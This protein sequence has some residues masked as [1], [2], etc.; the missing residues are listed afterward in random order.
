MR[1][2]TTT[3]AI[4]ALV[5]MGASSASAI[6]I[7]FEGQANGQAI[8]GGEFPGV[9]ISSSDAGVTHS[10]P[11]IFDSNPAGPNAAGG[12]PDLLVNTGNL[13]I[14]QNNA[15]PTQTTPGIFDTPNDEADYGPSN[16]GHLLFSFDPLGVEVQSILLVDL[17]GGA[18]VDI[19]LT[20][21][22]GNT[23][24]YFVPE[25]WTKDIADCGFTCA[26][27]KVF[28]LQTLA[29]QVGEEPSNSTTPAPTVTGAYD[30][31][32]V[33][34]MELRFHG[35]SPSAAVDN[36]SFVPEPSTALLLG[37]GLAAMAGT[38]RRS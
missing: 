5:L 22:L 24:E 26:G 18:E 32:S 10:G 6:T 4:G 20:D 34:S 3:A 21:V 14:L 31:F 12:D 35:T 38:R 15:F 7:D 8:S 33:L 37:L 36:L 25:M 19:I 30:K 9:T 16:E 23:L 28:D 29:A 27:F 11:A 17:N 2:L 1:G 13:L